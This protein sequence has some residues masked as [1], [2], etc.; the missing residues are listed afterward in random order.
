M[1]TKIPGVLLFKENHEH[2]THKCAFINNI[3]I[4]YEIANII[5]K[6]TLEALTSEMRPISGRD[7][8]HCSL[9]LTNRQKKSIKE[10]H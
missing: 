8:S 5:N 3:L 10:K 1:V 2:F 4:T 6:D 9:L 7:H